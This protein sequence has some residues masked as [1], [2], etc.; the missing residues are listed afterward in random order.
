MHIPALGQIFVVSAF[1]EK[2][3]VCGH[4]CCFHPWWFPSPKCLMCLLLMLEVQIF[5]AHLENEKIQIKLISCNF[6]TSLCSRPGI[7]INFTTSKSPTDSKYSYSFTFS[8]KW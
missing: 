7:M 5:W 8:D 4:L 2:R 6:L 3:L 1:L